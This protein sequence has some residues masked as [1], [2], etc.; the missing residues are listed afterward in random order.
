M[1]AWVNEEFSDVWDFAR[2]MSKNVW[3]DE[4]PAIKIKIRISEASHRIDK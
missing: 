2:K 1:F 3:G 4:I